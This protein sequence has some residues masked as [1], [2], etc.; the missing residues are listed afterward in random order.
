MGPAHG[1]SSDSNYVQV[2]QRL[3]MLQLSALLSAMELHFERFHVRNVIMYLRRSRRVLCT[4]HV[5]VVTVGEI[6]VSK[7]GRELQTPVNICCVS[8]L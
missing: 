7:R 5:D 8:I 1:W 4:A 3:D 2:P 6:H